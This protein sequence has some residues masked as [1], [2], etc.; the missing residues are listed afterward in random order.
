MSKSRK[1]TATGNPAKTIW[2]LLTIFVLLP[3]LLCTGIVTWRIGRNGVAQGKLDEQ[4]EQLQL[5]GLPVDDASMQVYYERLTEDSNSEIWIEIVETLSSDAV[6]QQMQNLPIVGSGPDIP[7]LDEPWNEQQAVTALLARLQPTIEQLHGVAALDHAVRFPRKFESFDTL[8]PNVQM[9]RQLGRVLSLEHAVAIRE[10]DAEREFRAINSGLGTSIALR[11]DPLLVSKLV[12]VALHGIAMANLQT[13]IRQG[14]L[15]ADHLR[16]LRERLQQFE[17]FKTQFDQAL[18]GERAMGLAIFA[19]PNRLAQLEQQ[20]PFILSFLASPQIDALHYV[21][22]LQQAQTFR[23]DSLE[24]FA[25]DAEEWDRTVNERLQASGV[26]AIFDQ[27]MTG[28][29]LPGLEATAQAIIR[30]AMLNRLGTVAIAIRQYELQTGELPTDLAALTQVGLQLD[31]VKP[32]H[33]DQFGY[34]IERDNA[35]LWGYAPRSGSS[36]TATTGVPAEPPPIAADGT[37]DEGQLALNRIWVWEIK[38]R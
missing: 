19:D 30:Q 21:M 34:R 27:R 5:A 8:L 10:G 32:I 14:N 3:G 20:T 18:N 37:T 36:Q 23:D 15:A 11:G 22:L 2:I 1:Q 26:G 35:V 4:I 9:M 6:T 13:S 31:Q 28:M 29:M 24:T 17:D 33:G 16:Q 7:P 38:P 25:A 12:S